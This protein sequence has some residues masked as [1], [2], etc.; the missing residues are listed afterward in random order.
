MINRKQLTRKQFEFLHYLKE[1]IRHNAEWPTY[2]DI[3]DAFDFKSPNSVT[4]NLQALVK[5]GYLDRDGNGY[6]FPDD[7]NG[8]TPKGIQIRGMI[9]AG[10]L[11][12]AVE[13]DLGEITLEM[14]FPNLDRIFALKVQGNSMIGDGIE[15]GDYI[16]LIDDD[17]P[18][19]GIGAVMYDGETTLKRVYHDRHGLRLEAANP[20]YA[21]IR[22]DPGIFEEVRVLGKYIGRIATDGIY[23]AA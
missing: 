22:I 8:N 6:F 13:D 7:G 12:E 18:N 1:Y 15:H 5:K 21:D 4:Q 16:L 2:A 17:I 20:E 23:R 14:L 9:T 10:A 11:Q 19:G 3:A